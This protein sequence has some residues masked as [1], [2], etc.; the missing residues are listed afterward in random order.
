[1]KEFDFSKMTDEELFALFKKLKKERE[2]RLCKTKESVRRT[3]DFYQAF[4]G[5]NIEVIPFSRTM[6]D[7]GEGIHNSLLTICDFLY[8]NYTINK[9]QNGKEHI[10]RKGSYIEK[11]YEDYKS[12]YDKLADLIIDEIK[13]KGEK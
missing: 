12:F 6:Y 5:R 11:N 7:A 2:N 1:M 10:K 9:T 3:S 8:G 4:T 13:Q